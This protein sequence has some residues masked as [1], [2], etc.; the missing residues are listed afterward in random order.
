[1][2]ISLFHISEILKRNSYDIIRCIQISL[3]QFRLD[4]NRQCQSYKNCFAIEMMVMIVTM[5]ST[6]C[7]LQN[8][9]WW[10]L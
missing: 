9:G 4:Y 3:F 7:C 5:N 2:N 1:M 10:D 8:N 6:T